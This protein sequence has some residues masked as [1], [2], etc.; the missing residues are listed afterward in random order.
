M[1]KR[2]YI[3]ESQFR[4][5]LFE[6]EGGNMKHARKYLE[7]KGYPPEQRQKILDA[8]RTDIP[9]SRL[10]QCKFLLGVTRL[11]MEGQ[12]KDGNSISQLNKALKYIASDAHVNEYDYNLNEEN[13]DTLVQRFSGVAKADLEQ[14]IAASNARQ[15]TP[16][17]DYTIVPINSPKEAAK[18][19]KYT[20]WCVTHYSNM[21]DSYTANGKGRFYFCLRR[22]FENELKMKGEG[23]PLDSYG[24]SMIAVSVTMEGEV[25]TIT[26]RWNHDNG[27]N[28]NIMTIEQLENL[29][30]RNFY[31]TF[32]PYT[33]EELH[34]KGVI[35]F[36][37]V[38]GLLD[39]GKKP[40]EIFDGVDSFQNGFAVVL[41]ND[42]KNL[43]STEGKLVSNQWFDGVDSFQNGFAIVKLND[44]WNLIN[45][46]GKLVSNQWFDCA[47]DFR[48]GFAVVLLNN[49]W[50]FINTEGKLVSNQWFDGVSC[51]Q[52]GFA[53]VKLND[54]KNLINTESKL[55]SN[56]WFDWVGCFQNGFA[57]VSL[58]GKWN[59]ISTEGKLI[60]NQ[61]FDMMHS[62]QDGFAI[63]KLNDKWNFINTEGKFV[64]NQWF[65][66]VGDFRDGFAWVYLNGRWHKIDTEGN[67]YNNAG[68][69][70]ITELK[71]KNM[72][73]RIYITESQFQQI[74]NTLSEN[75]IPI[76]NDLPNYYFVSTLSMNEISKTIDVGSLSEDELIELLLTYGD[77]NGKRQACYDGVEI[78]KNKEYAFGYHENAMGEEVCDLLRND[79]I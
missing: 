41:L 72:G 62:F 64:S 1:N 24:L 44:K 52:D 46:E 58:N 74:I 54:K 28:D 14:S 2:I 78:S 61:W 38:Q 45:T 22:G 51:F 15:L 32:K 71:N 19:G 42:K 56:Q 79:N 63:V 34:A 9:N 3:T 17:K 67:L 53:I 48:D 73:K 75:H 40:E 66:G 25:N 49:K 65:D 26:C 20:S 16:N 77:K 29:L 21:Y 7:A 76:S 6:N 33:R 5:I 47:S 57:R 68:E 43:I 30:G 69:K 13:L 23:C 60:S 10:Q 12:L 11:Y 70:V 50:N 31:Q 39:S 35:L 37:E 27:G 59:L 18:Y 8:I 36:D 55:V 4:R